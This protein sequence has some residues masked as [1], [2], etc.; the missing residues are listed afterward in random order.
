MVHGAA[1]SK[2]AGL[3]PLYEEAARAALRILRNDREG[4]HEQELVSLAWSFAT[5]G[6]GAPELFDALAAEAE[7]MMRGFSPQ[8]LA[9]LA[10]A[11]ATA[12]HRTRSLFDAVAAEATPQLRRFTPQEVA[13]IAWAFA[14][15]D[16]RNLAF[17]DKLIQRMAQPGPPF[18]SEQH[19]QMNPF[20]FWCVVELRLPEAQLPSQAMRT[21]CRENF[22]S[23]SVRR[24]AGS[25]REGSRTR[26]AE[27]CAGSGCRQRRTTSWRT[28]SRLAMRFSMSGSRSRW[29][30]RSSLFG[31]VP[32]RGSGRWARSCSSDGSC[33]RS[34]G[35]FL[36]CR[37]GSGTRCRRGMEARSSRLRGQV[38]L[39]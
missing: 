33:R 3:T 15:A 39:Y 26:S 25:R 11:F 28:A 9:N 13:M 12:A 22:A 7:R 20:V 32:A 38:V 17:V 5:A 37:S 24:H 4:F 23:Y 14:A 30:G 2:A 27:R 21:R 18:T 19:R 36:A 1:V 29:T 31:R 6:H 34:D 10:W 35:P 16:E 8:G